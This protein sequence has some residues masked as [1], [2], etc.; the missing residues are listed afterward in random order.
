MI[1]S[2]ARFPVGRALS[3][4]LTA[5]FGV[6]ALSMV[7]GEAAP[8]T[9][10][11]NRFIGASKCKSCHSSEASGDQHAVWSKMKH[12]E[13]FEVLASDAAKKTA[14]ALGIADP[15]TADECLR[16]HVTAFG[17]P[18]ER[19][20]RGFKKELGVQCESCHGAGEKHMKA[21]FKA[22]AT[23]EEGA[24]T[25]Y[26]PLPPGE[27]ELEATVGVCTACHNP[28]SPNYKP[29]CFYEGRAKT[30]HLNPLKPRS[31]EEL[32]EW[33]K[34]PSGDACA[35]ENGCPDEKCNLTPE[36]LQELK[37]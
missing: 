37:Q 3:L 17:E 23:A 4:A 26:Q 11:P 15:Q 25:A 13:A 36:K 7:R 8:E 2:R 10:K 28:Q 31:A 20:A 9:A 12:A 16:C 27:M 21:R 35:H 19:L 1:H 32:A 22:A 18:E 29:F 34:C 33:P 5:A 14:E 24:D 6:L 30:A